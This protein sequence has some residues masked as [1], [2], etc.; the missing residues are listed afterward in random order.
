MPF[1]SLRQAAIASLIAANLSI[2]PSTQAQPPVAAAE[3][4]APMMF[5]PVT[6]SALAEPIYPV[7][8]TDGLYH[9]S[10]EF[11]L[12]NDL[13]GTFVID[14]VKVLDARTR[15]PT[16]NNRVFAQDGPEVTGRLIRF[17]K[18]VN[19]NGDQFSD[20]FTNEL[21][22][23]EAGIIYFDLTYPTRKAIPKRLVHRF[24]GHFEDGSL[25]G[26]S[27]AAEDAGIAVS[28]QPAIRVHPPLEGGDWIDGN[29]A[30]AV[31]SMHRYTYAPT[32]GRLHPMERFAIDFM[33]LNAEG[34]T[35]E[36]DP[37]RL[38]SYFGYGEKVLSA[39][40]GRVVAT[41]DGQDEQTPNHLV[42]PK[43]FE[44]YGGNYVIVA[45]G[46]GK[47]A[48]YGHLKPGSLAVRKGQ[49]VR[50]GQVLG[51]LGNSGNSDGPHLHFQIMN[52]PDFFNTAALPFVFDRMMYR[53][54]V[55]GAY[56]PAN[57][58]LSSGAAEIIDTRGAGPRINQMPVSM[59][60]MEFQ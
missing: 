44:D 57:V 59:D 33:K 7:K 32:N 23:G 48:A 28:A 10:Y 8:G 49:R 3:K 53:G 6:W 51:L 41:V 27:F 38:E 21:A 19:D 52:T 25:A 11:Q 39:T 55:P 29:G 1:H 30:G 20:A 56:D 60:V 16:G 5:S 17:A 37:D 58:A 9:L 50:V 24:T 54:H 36:G 15:Q 2:A 18:P 26:Q 12:S 31:I 45:I 47:Y 40:N 13:R 35:L 43:R 42:P 14:S 22:L 46:G 34:K 4:F